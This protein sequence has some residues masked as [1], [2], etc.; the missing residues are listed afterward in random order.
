[1]P[2]QSPEESVRETMEELER[3][4]R[5]ASQT[6]PNCGRPPPDHATTCPH[7]GAVLDAWLPDPDTRARSDSSF[8][9]ASVKRAGRRQSLAAPIPRDS[10]AE[11][12]GF[13][14]KIE[15]EVASITESTATGPSALSWGVVGARRLTDRRGGARLWGPVTVGSLSYLSAIPPLPFVPDSIVPHAGLMVLG[16]LLVALGVGLSAGSAR[17]EAPTKAR[18]S[19]GCPLCGTLVDPTTANCPTCGARLR[20]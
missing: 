20:T 5:E 13:V 14:V 19:D 4:I 18:A 8:R 16:T 15:S 3:T 2:P 6:C 17:G 9:R 1:M 12:E 7:C 11:I 10:G